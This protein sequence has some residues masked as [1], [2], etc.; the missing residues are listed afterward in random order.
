MNIIEMAWQGNEHPTYII[1]EEGDGNEPV[2]EQL[3]TEGDEEGRWFD[4]PHTAWFDFLKLGLM[5]GWKQEGTLLE[6]RIKHRPFGPSPE[7]NVE[8]TYQPSD[9]AYPQLILKSDAAAWADA[10]EMALKQMKAGTLEYTFTKGPTI[11]SESMT[12]A[13]MIKVNSPATLLKMSE[14]IAWL[15]MGAFIFAYD[16]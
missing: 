2:L 11:I 3:S 16:D 1:R 13:E 10:L 15:R 14:F 4:L 8:L 5:F 7:K 9:W 6:R 12:P